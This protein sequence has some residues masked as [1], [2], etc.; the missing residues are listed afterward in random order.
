MT[1]TTAYGGR[2]RRGRTQAR[3]RR[4]GLER[5][6]GRA[7]L[8]ASIDIAA[9]GSLVY[10]SDPAAVQSLL[11]STAAGVYTFA[12]APGD[13][14][15]DVTNNA[16]GL[17]VTGSGGGTVTVAGPASLRIEAAF[18]GQTVRV[19][20]TA[21]AT[22]IVL[23][24]DQERV[25]LGDDQQAG[26]GGIQALA[27]PITVSAATGSELNSLLVDDG[28]AAYDAGS[29]PSYVVSATAITSND[30]TVRARFAGIAY[31]GVSTLTV[32]GTSNAQAASPL[33]LV[34]G[35]AAGAATTIDGSAGPAHR[36]FS[37][38]GT[39]A[40]PTSSLSLLG[41]GSA[42]VWV[43]SIDSPTTYSGDGSRA[44]IFLEAVRSG[45]FG[46]DSNFVVQDAGGAVDLSIANYWNLGGRRGTPDWFLG[47]DPGS[48]SPFAALRDATNAAVGG[49]F[50]QPDQ[51]HSL[52]LD[53]RGNQGASL[54]VDF[55]SGDPLPHGPAAGAA[56]DPRAGLTY[57]GAAGV[58]PGSPYA[59]SL[60]G[61]P[62]TGAFAA[63]SV[64]AFPL[65][66]GLVE[67]TEAGGGIRNIAY[68]LDAAAPLLDDA[69]TVA[70]YRWYY[71]IMNGAVDGLRTLPDGSTVSAVLDSNLSVTAG[72]TSIAGGLSLSLVEQNASAFMARF[73]I[74]AKTNARL[75]R[76]WSLGAVTT[77]VNYQYADAVAERVAGL[78]SLSVED[79][80][81]PDTPT[82]DVVR[83]QSAPP[84]AAAYVLQNGGEDS[85]AV[86]L[87]G[88]A[89]A[90]LVGLDGGGG[91]DTLYIDA[92]GLPLSTS[93]FQ[94]L[95]GGAFLIAG[96]NVAAA[97]VSARGYEAVQVYNSS[98][99]T[100]SIQPVAVQ[101]QARV[102]LT[103]VTAGVL[104]ATIAGFSP[105]G[106]TV[107]IGW[108]DGTGSAG[109]IVAVPGAPTAFRVVGTHTYAQ[110]GVYS[111]RLF[112]SGT[113]TATSAVAGVPITFQIAG[114][115][116]TTA[117][118]PALSGRLAAASD[119]GVS[120]SDGITNVTLPTFQ[121][122]NAI[123]G[124]FIEIF[125]TTPGLGGTTTR[126][127]TAFAD[128]AGAWTV[129]ST[130]PLADGSYT[131][132]AVS[133][134]TSTFAN[135]L[136]TITSPL[137]VDTL[138]P[139]VWNVTADVLRGE[140]GVAIR[141]YG[142]IADGG[143]GLD[144]ARVRDAAS[145]A[146]ATAGGVAQTIA[147]ASVSPGSNNGPQNITLHMGS[148]LRSGNFVLTVFTSAGRAAGIRDI[149]G[150]PLDGAFSGAFPS[151]GAN[152]GGD[153]RARL[154]LS[155]NRLQSIRPF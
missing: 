43:A 20:S 61:A 70:A 130:V 4:P 17:T 140:V 122:T 143:S 81:P 120:D 44:A 144:L 126:L 107:V 101:A 142:G 63:E 153:F 124:A 77:V 14:P 148:R 42:N 134:S 121:G 19:R 35:T 75:L 28:P 136:A 127:G 71:D 69:A 133:T 51:V 80:S 97:P 65:Y 92:Q 48:A 128:A 76:G 104:T 39:S 98:T 125:A 100:F 41:A 154:S 31:S 55:R 131:I 1:M 87:K 27:G 60:V 138:G 90:T 85:A 86:S 45:N 99:P 105:T 114:S 50:F 73:L 78:A 88:T 95:G 68:Q 74:S 146:Y 24:G 8:N 93:N 5:L 91:Q 112:V 103:G 106:L 79:A 135:G 58:H 67:L 9:D 89:G 150:N 21:V 56:D 6:E 115:T 147:S 84:G 119:S 52:G 37:I 83:L 32:R 145:Y 3:A 102:P 64:Q 2:D 66:R 10:R 123:A 47:F 18:G 72:G 149:A 26:S 137:V 12:V 13:P 36:D 23:Q 22:A 49:V 62:T 139:R 16:A 94:D 108:G 46:I 33:Y 117:A 15:I 29:A 40:D 110:S 132:Q 82:A 25:I 38:Q 54:M 30:P 53:A 155:N 57:I 151:G 129:A 109:T 7:L 59:L 34:L 11:V 141:D 113:G 118:A 111:P 152:T 96:T 116:G